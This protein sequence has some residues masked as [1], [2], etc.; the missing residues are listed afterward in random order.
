MT[1]LLV[2]LLA[3]VGFA[4]R[5]LLGYPIEPPLTLIGAHTLPR[6]W[7]RSSLG[8]E[9]PLRG[10]SSRSC[11][12]DLRGPPDAGHAG[13]RGTMNGSSFGALA[14]ADTRVV[15]R[16]PLLKWVLLLPIGLAL[17]L[18]VLIPKARG[19]L[20]FAGFEAAQYYPLVMG[21]YS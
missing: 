14:Y 2:P 19:S 16:D 12:D 11:G 6:A 3:H 20:V 5:S 7:E 10:V 21:G 17:L 15:W 4:P 8:A 18:R 13:Q 1:L 9:D